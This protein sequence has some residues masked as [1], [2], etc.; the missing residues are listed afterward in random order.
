MICHHNITAIIVDDEQDARELLEIILHD[1]EIIDI[2]GEFNSIEP[3][4]E[5][6]ITNQPQLVFLDINMPGKNGFELVEEIRS[7]QLNPTII[8]TTAHSEYSI[9]AIENEAFGYLIKPINPDKLRKV[10]HRFS[11]RNN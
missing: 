9:Q 1:I 7:L 8:F 2:V 4:I 5:F 11:C 6:I 10:I 3:A